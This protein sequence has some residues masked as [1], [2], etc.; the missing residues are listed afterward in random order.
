M[1]KPES[2]KD[3]KIYSHSSTSINI[4]IVDDHMLFRTG[5]RKMLEGAS[6]IKIVG[7]AENGVQAIQVVRE[8]SPN[9]VLMDINMPEM[10]GLSAIPK[11]LRFN[12]N[13]KIII[14][15]VH[16]HS[17]FPIQML[18]AGIAGYLTKGA[19]LEEMLQAIRA[20][21]AGQVHLSPGIAKKLAFMDMIPFEEGIFNVLS[22]RELQIAM[23]IIQ[24]F[25]AVDIGK[26]LCLSSKTINSYRYR[27]FCKLAITNDV[28]LTLLAIR[29]GLSESCFRTGQ[30]QDP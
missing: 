27:I 7:E 8:S 6:G 5:V 1:L 21:H 11:L 23:M 26:K 17:V 20:A 19:S 16:D 3:K 25:R 10:D 22:Q 2:R 29:A 4:V 30:R 15:T 9:V 13:L 14:I 18:Q 12:S 24:G 28:E